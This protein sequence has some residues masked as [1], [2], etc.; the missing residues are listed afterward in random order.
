MKMSHQT[1][2]FISVYIIIG[3][4]CAFIPENANATETKFDM[5]QVTETDRGYP[6]LRFLHLASQTS[7][8]LTYIKS[9]SCAD[10]KFEYRRFVEQT[11]I[12]PLDS[13][14]TGA[15]A[16]NGKRFDFPAT[17]P[18]IFNAAS[19]KVMQV[20]WT[21]GFPFFSE[22]IKADR[23]HWRD[24]TM[25]SDQASTEITLEGFMEIFNTAMDMCHRQYMIDNSRSQILHT[26]ATQ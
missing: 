17:V 15:F 5:W 3:M 9:T 18:V 20:V 21:L 8:V 1:R 13:E 25:V 14:I 12:I 6:R 24:S 23:L 19:L 22:L 11:E 16:I 2:F 4:A 10:V 7:F 26:M